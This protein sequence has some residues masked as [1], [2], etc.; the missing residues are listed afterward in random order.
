VLRLSRGLADD[1]TTP[2]GL[3][4]AVQNAVRLE[5]S[6]IPPYL[7]ALYSIEPGTN[8]EIARLILSVVIDEMMHMAF[9]CNILNALGGTPVIDEPGFIP[10]YPGTLPGSVETG[11]QVSLKK[12]SR[13]HVHDTFMVIEEP[14]DRLNFPTARLAAAPD[15]TIGQFYALIRAQMPTATFPGDPAKQITHAMMPDVFAVTDADSAIAA[16]DLIVEQGEGT[17]TSP[18]DGDAEGDLAHFYRFAE[19]WHERKLVKNPDPDLPPDKQ[20]SYTGDPIPIDPAGVRDAAENPQRSS[21]EPGSQAL[22][23]FDNFNYTYTSL[24]KSLHTTFNGTPGDL[25]SAIGL[26]ESCKEQAL[27]L[28]AIEL[29]GGGRAGP[30]FLWQPTNP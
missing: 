9:A 26:M 18:L 20:Y 15:L 21:F 27:A 13:E 11:L 3:T 14:E 12:L 19:I 10:T 23:L 4:T 22:A 1:L 16:I 25:D 30:G 28:T 8:S 29:P 24:L 6:T 5:H 7:Y 17:K 2:D